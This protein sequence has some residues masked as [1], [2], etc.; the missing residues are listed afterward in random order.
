M[1]SQGV[2]DFEGRYS[3]PDL[4]PGLWRVLA[5]MEP[6]GL[7]ASGKVTLDE[8]QAEAKLDLEFKTGYDVQGV[9]RTAGQPPSGI[10]VIASGLEVGLGVAQV[11]SDGEGRFR[12][13]QL[14]AGSYRLFAYTD[15]AQHSR[16]IEIP[17]DG[18]V[19]YELGVQRI[20]GHVREESGERPLPGVAVRIEGLDTGSDV[21]TRSSTE[22]DSRGYF[23]LGANEGAHHLIATK[24]GYGASEITV[25]VPAGGRHEGLELRLVPTDGVSFDL[26]PESGTQ[27]TRVMTAVADLSGRV[28]TKGY[29]QVG[30]GGTV[31]LSTVPAGTWELA[32][33]AGDSAVVRR[34][35]TAP[36]HSGQNPPS[37]RWGP[38][39]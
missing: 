13:S 14:P 3:V 31:R 1:A 9:L 30:E 4:G 24:A 34:T 21:Y 22:T 6:S 7:Q 28:L 39:D 10:R 18:E 36:G 23:S 38:A 26:L 11:V 25:D 8:G 29:V 32:V 35:L 17:A 16:A 5:L 27:P 19:V 20:T 37:A 15:M 2:V 12:F 33:Q